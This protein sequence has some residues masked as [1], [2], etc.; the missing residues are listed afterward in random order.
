MWGGATG[1]EIK[2]PEPFSD[3]SSEVFGSDTG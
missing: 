3:G 1:V 2:T